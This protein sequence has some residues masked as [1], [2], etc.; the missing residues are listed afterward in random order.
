MINCF[1][2]KLLERVPPI[3]SFTLGKMWLG[4]VVLR[5]ESHVSTNVLPTWSR[6]YYFL[7][8]YERETNERKS[9]SQKFRHFC[10]FSPFNVCEKN[11]T[12]NGAVGKKWT[13]Y[14]SY[15]IVNSFKRK[16]FVSLL[17]CCSDIDR[18]TSIFSMQ[19][20]CYKIRYFNPRFKNEFHMTVSIP[21]VMY[22]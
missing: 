11:I 9:F 8:T 2:I 6:H 3:F 13:C 10:C 16:T 20:E 15:R 7:F 1:E 18:I 5:V 21:K 19:L 17:V 12:I 14:F 22:M 4:N